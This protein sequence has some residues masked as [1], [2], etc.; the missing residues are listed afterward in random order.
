MKL[1]WTGCSLDT[2]QNID[3][4]HLEAVNLSK[5]LNMSKIETEIP[6]VPVILSNSTVSITSV[7]VVEVSVNRRSHS[8]TS[9]FQSSN[10]TDDLLLTEGNVTV[11]STQEFDG[12]EGNKVKK[13]SYIDLDTSIMDY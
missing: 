9:D 11:E 1:I 7:T 8:I 2:I 5:S 3:I 12:K 6:G 4:T 13:K 10:S